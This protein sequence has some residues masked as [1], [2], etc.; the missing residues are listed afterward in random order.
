M[1]VVNFFGGPGAGKS[2]AA[3]GLFYKMKS[4]HVS[5]ELVTEYAKDAVWECRHNLMKDQL[6]LLAKQNRRIARLLEHPIRFAVTDSPILLCAAYA[7]IGGNY[8]D[9]LLIPMILEVFNGYDN[10]NILIQRDANTYQ[11][12]GREQNIEQAKEVDNVVIDLLHKYN[13]PYETVY[14]KPDFSTVD[15]VY[16]IVMAR[17]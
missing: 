16:E 10:I 1:K 4:S 8:T 2:T 5:A 7:E 17:A 9:S 13:I 15:E 12:V 11:Q 6:Y 14:A 3:A